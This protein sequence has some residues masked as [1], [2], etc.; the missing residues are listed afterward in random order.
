VL[1]KCIYMHKCAMESMCKLTK[2]YD[3]QIPSQ[4]L[5]PVM[6]FSTDNVF[7]FGSAASRLPI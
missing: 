3:I 4:R 5:Y 6:Q 2:D 1:C 7:S